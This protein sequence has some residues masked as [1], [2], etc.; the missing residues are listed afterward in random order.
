MMFRT[1]AL[2]LAA[3]IT[4]PLLAAC[5]NGAPLIGATPEKAVIVPVALVDETPGP[6]LKK[7]AYFAGGC[8]WGVQ[9]VFQHVDGVTA[10]VSGYLGGTADTAYYGAVSGGG[11]GH[12]ETVRVTYDPTQI[13]YA[14]LLQV[15][16]SVAHNPTQLN[17]Q[18]PDHGTQYR[19]AVFPVNPEQARVATA[20]IDQ[21]N[22]AD[23]FPAEVVTT[24]EPMTGFYVAEANHQD[25]LTLNPLSA[26]IQV[27]DMPKLD[28]L[29][30]TFP[31]LWRDQPVLVGDS[32]TGGTGGATVA[33]AE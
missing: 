3:L 33:T 23:V 11:T 12:A 6:F 21:L 22:A 24:V 7:T 25:Y 18:G 1:I 29:K 26:Y 16:F 30:A 2:G 13:S 5:D 27:N 17:F 9:A 32:L 20:Y 19:S 14:K 15:Y 8:F 28:N 31:D 10:A 4:L